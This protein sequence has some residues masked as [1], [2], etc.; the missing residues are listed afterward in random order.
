MKVREVELRQN[1]LPALQILDFRQIL[2]TSGRQLVRSTTKQAFCSLRYCH[3][4]GSRDELE[5]D[6]RVL[7][8]GISREVTGHLEDLARWHGY[9]LTLPVQLYRSQKA[10]ADRE[11]SLL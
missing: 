4:V 2:G 5:C 6:I 1:S 11:Q 9:W 3:E 7:D 8:S 10:R